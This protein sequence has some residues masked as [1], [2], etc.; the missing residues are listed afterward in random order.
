MKKPKPAADLPEEIDRD[1]SAA[2]ACA[3]HAW[4]VSQLTRLG[5]AGAVAE[6]VADSVDWH[7]IAALVRQGCPADV[8]LAIIA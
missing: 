3:V 6:A 2:D 5:L 8:A 7:D 4:R 1:A